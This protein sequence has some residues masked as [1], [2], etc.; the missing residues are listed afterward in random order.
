MKLSVESGGWLLVLLLSFILCS[1]GLM[2]PSEQQVPAT[3]GV[4][5]ISQN[6]DCLC[7]AACVQMVTTYLHQVN[8]GTVPII[9]E[10]EAAQIAHSGLADSTCPPDTLPWD[11]SWDFEWNPSDVLT[12]RSFAVRSF[13]AENP[14]QGA[15]ADSLVLPVDSMAEELS[16]HRPVIFVWNW[17]GLFVSLGDT[18]LYGSQPHFLVA[19]GLQPSP[20][21]AG[22]SGEVWVAVNDPEPVM[23]GHHRLMLYR[24]FTNLVPCSMRQDMREGAYDK[25]FMFTQHGGDYIGISYNGGAVR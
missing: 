22:K 8:P 21:N 11:S 4:P 15:R 25:N 2:R 14:R 13:A 7:W 18:E 17:A 23:H 19:E 6:A 12:A 10:C 16:H 1:T 20:F 3:L 9:T 5:L 24:V